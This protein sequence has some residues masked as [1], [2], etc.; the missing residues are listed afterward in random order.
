MNVVDK[1]ND[2]GANTMKGTNSGVQ[3][4]ITDIEPNAVADVHCVT[5]N[6]NLVLNDAV[7]EVIQMQTF[8]ETVPQ[9]YNFFGHRIKKCNILLSF[10]SE[11][12]IATLQNL[13]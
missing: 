13:K 6:L 9:I 1:D 2:R 8:F 7:N 4:L 3:T 5:R 11:N 12:K 10:I